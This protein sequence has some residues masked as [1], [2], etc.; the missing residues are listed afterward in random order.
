MVVLKDGGC[1]RSNVDMAALPDR[2]PQTQAVETTAPG[3]KLGVMF[4]GPKILASEL[5]RHIRDM[6]RSEDH[7]ARGIDISFLEGEQ[8][9]SRGRVEEAG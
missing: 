7:K 5:R 4:C 6:E 9:E 3:D 1:K 2:P 8:G